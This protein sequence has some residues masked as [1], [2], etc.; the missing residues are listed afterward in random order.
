MTFDKQSN[1][2]RI[3][4][5]SYSCNHR[6]SCFRVV[7]T[8]LCDAIQQSK[9]VMAHCVV[10][11]T[12]SLFHSTLKTQNIFHKLFPPRKSASIR[13][14]DCLFGIRNWTR[15]IALDVF[16][17]ACMQRAIL[18]CQIRPSVC[19]SH[20]GIVSKRVRVFSYDKQSKC[21][22][23]KRRPTACF[24]ATVTCGLT[25]GNWLSSSST[26]ISSI[27]N[28][29]YL[30]ENQGITFPQLCRWPP[31]PVRDQPV[32]GR[33]RHRSGSRASRGGGH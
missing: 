17:R 23:V 30:Y 12:I 28:N 18:L 26:L 3:E 16:Y 27:W 31:S 33:P 32:R 5:E 9:T 29:K 6:V 7:R 13:R 24:M 10:S 1:V 22:N 11:S 4:V 19:P 15:L 8:F 2:R 20:S 14:T 21:R 25:A